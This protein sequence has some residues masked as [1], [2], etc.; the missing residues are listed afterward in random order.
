MYLTYYARYGIYNSMNIQENRVK[1]GNK[2]Y[3]YARLVRSYRRKDGKPAVKVVANLGELP[4]QE[5]KNLKIAFRAA[6][7]GKAVVISDTATAKAIPV[8]V[9]ANLDYLDIMVALEM[10]DS[11]DLSSLIE[12]IIPRQQDEVSPPCVISALVVQRCVSPGS[13]LYAQRWYPTTALPEVLDMLPEQFNNSRIHRVL[14]SLDRATPVLQ[15]NLPLLYQG[16]KGKPITL[17]IDVTDAVFEGRGCEMA[18][19]SRTKSGLRNRR[20]IGVVLLCDETG[21]PLRWEVVPGNR[22]DHHCLGEMVDEMEKLHW[23]GGAPIIFDRAMGQANALDRLLGSGLRFITAVPRNEISA[24]S[25]QLPYER[26]LD[27]E[28]ATPHDPSEE[29]GENLPE[30]LQIYRAD[31][32]CA[33]RLAE[34]SELE[35]VDENLYVTD[36]GLGNRPLAENEMQWVGP[37]DI[38]PEGLKGAASSLAWAR[39]FR[40]VLKSREVKDRATLA[41]MTG[42]SRARVTEMMNLLKLDRDI[43]D[44]ILAGEY[45]CISEHTM[46]EVVKCASEEKQREMLLKYKQQQAKHPSSHP[47]KPRK[48]RLTATHQ[49]KRVVYF[50][51]QMFID[52]RLRDRKHRT[53]S[54]RFIDDLNRRL[55]S[56]YSQRDEESIRFEIMEYLSKKKSLKLYE[57]HIRRE[58]DTSS[59]RSFWQVELIL[60]A[61][62]WQRRRSFHG[63]V[64]LVAHKDL[65]YTAA[66]VAGLYRAKDTIEKD[67]KIIKDVV[68]LQPIYHH[69][70]PKVRAHVTLCMLAL[71][72]KR[73]LEQKLSAAGRP[74]TAAACFEKLSTCH[75]NLHEAHEAL[76]SLY[77]AT[78]PDKEQKTILAALGLSKLT[79]NRE[80]GGRITPR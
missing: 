9:K 18:Q 46:R 10:W 40:R 73:T 70:D 63:F 1:S 24:H 71:L 45:G 21:I 26:F 14:E 12:E 27:F 7:Q 76:E 39:I 17:F 64:L 32:E 58:K 44:E 74:M 69:T 75:L 13:K 6:R 2:Y 37:D 22:R 53:E 47:M 19:R 66:E 48:F 16:R 20:K 15:K 80:I 4:S 52:K 43:Q 31:V 30:I 5:I 49:L 11:W 29:D 78:E 62:E 59:D 36:L 79:D 51:P 55:Y 65:S 41:G 77:S 38:D 3:H 56:P 61:K 28:P 54:A 8:P 72:V 42:V 68:E 57:I 25:V 67:F 35:R 34:E 23:I 60:N 33:A 50:N